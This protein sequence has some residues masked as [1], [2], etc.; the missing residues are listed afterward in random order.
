MDDRYQLED[1]KEVSAATSVTSLKILN[2]LTGEQLNI[3]EV[4]SRLGITMATANH[5]IKQLEEAGLVVRIGE[6]EESKHDRQRFMALTNQFGM[7]LYASNITQMERLKR[8]GVARRAFE[9]AL[10]K[11]ELALTTIEP[12]NPQLRGTHGLAHIRVSRQRYAEMRQRAHKLISE[13]VSEQDYS[14]DDGIDCN[15]MLIFFPENE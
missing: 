14:G 9:D 1:P 2:L 12:R 6:D 4:A 3:S 15:L 5:Q 7:A 10:Q 8:I 11:W 13:Y